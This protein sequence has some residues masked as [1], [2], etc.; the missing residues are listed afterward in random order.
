MCFSIWQDDF[1]SLPLPSQNLLIYLFIYLV[2][3]PFL[4]SLPRHREVPR[5]GVELEP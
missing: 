1:P 4:E 5:L 2:F 3:L